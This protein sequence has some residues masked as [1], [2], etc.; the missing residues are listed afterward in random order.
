[1]HLCMQHS[2]TMTYDRQC[3][4]QGEHII[5]HWKYWLPYLIGNGRKNY[6]CEA[7]NLVCNIHTDLPELIIH[8]VV[9]NRTVNITRTH[10]KPIDQVV[11]HY[12]L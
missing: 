9:Q 11:E 6:Y 1:M 3:F 4:E 5:H 7:A 12:N 8:I 2:C 10:G